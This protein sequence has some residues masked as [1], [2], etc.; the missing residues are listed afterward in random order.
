MCIVPAEVGDR[1]V[2]PQGALEITGPGDLRIRPGCFEVGASPPVAFG[3]GPV[4]GVIDKLPELLPGDF[5]AADIE[6]D[7]DACQSLR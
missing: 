3:V 4:A 6:G 1:M 7:G 5:G 2:I